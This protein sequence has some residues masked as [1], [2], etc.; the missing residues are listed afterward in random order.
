[1]GDNR[2]ILGEMQRLACLCEVRTGEIDKGGGG[3]GRDSEKGG[4]RRGREEEREKEE[5]GKGESKRETIVEG[6]RK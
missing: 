6:G 1:L 5:G 4:R 3:R 2:S